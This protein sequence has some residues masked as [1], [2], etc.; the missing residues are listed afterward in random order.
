VSLDLAA[1]FQRFRAVDSGRIHLAAHSHHYWPDVTLGAQVQCWEEA[2]QLADRKWE[3]IFETILPAVQRGIASRLGLP[4][5]A[6]IAVAPNTHSLLLRLL[7]CISPARPIRV[8]TSDGEFHSFTRQIARMEEEGLAEVTRIACAPLDSFA[9]R[10]LEACSR[11]DGDLVFVSHVF[12]DSAALA[13]PAEAIVAAVRRR[14]TF[15]VLDGYHAFMAL[16]VDLAAVADRIFYLGGGYKYAMAGEG[17]CF[18]HC[19]PGYGPRPRDTGWYAAFGALSRRDGSVAYAEDGG[20][21]LGATFDPSGLYRLKAV[22]EWMERLGLSIAAIHAH[23]IE[24]ADRL[25]EALDASRLAGL[26]RGDLITPLASGPSRGHFLAYAH[27]LSETNE[28]RL[29]AANVIVD[30][31]GDRLRF[32]IGCYHTQA[33]IERG[34]ARIR[35]ALG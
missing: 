3:H 25:A 16:P 24:L 35:E 23:V 27:P 34:L 12:F 10:F 31:R 17:A 19:P 22:F 1:H 20:R 33:E 8:L 32:G 26:S 7:S 4:D 29:M 13:P 11:F 5:P 9:A 14:D 21:F 28:R 2:A 15:I 30:R 6:S 18:L